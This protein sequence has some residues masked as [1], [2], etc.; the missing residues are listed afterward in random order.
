MTISEQDRAAALQA[1]DRLMNDPNLSPEERVRLTAIHRR[2]L[3]EPETDAPSDLAYAFA[4]EY[5]FV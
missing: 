2:G 3:L 4:K 1:G 5:M